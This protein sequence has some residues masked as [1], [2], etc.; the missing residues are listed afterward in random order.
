MDNAGAFRAPIPNAGRSFRPKY[1]PVREF[2][3]IGHGAQYVEDSEGKRALL[4]QVQPV[5]K[6]SGEP[7]GQIA[8]PTLLN[9]KVSLR[10]LAQEISQ[11]LSASGPESYKSLGVRLKARLAPHRLS[12]VHFFRMF[13]D[14]FEKTAGDKW[15]S[16]MQAAQPSAPPRRPTRR[17]GEKSTL[18]AANENPLAPRLR[19]S[20]KNTEQGQRIYEV[21]RYRNR[22]R[23]AAP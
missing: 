17:L 8:E 11:S 16:R 3:G 12:A 5:S 18:S 20:N 14:L 22:G 19:I 13:N 9:K 6:T 7:L 23:G 4:K 2:A 21:L 15:R 10:P 1:G